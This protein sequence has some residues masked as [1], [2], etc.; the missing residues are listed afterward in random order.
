V[1]FEE[2][3]RPAVSHAQ[4]G[5]TNF[6]STPRNSS[7]TMTWR[8]EAQRLYPAGR[9]PGDSRETTRRQPPVDHS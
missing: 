3:T 2:Q 1:R 4:T 9:R 8:P 7:A 5:C 6:G